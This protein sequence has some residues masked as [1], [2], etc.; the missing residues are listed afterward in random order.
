MNLSFVAGNCLHVFPLAVPLQATN[1][2]SVRRQSFSPHFRVHAH[3]LLD[4]LLKL[5]S[6]DVPCN[7]SSSDKFG[8]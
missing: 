6:A 1:P 2:Y 4:Q 8:R 5:A 7:S 3:S